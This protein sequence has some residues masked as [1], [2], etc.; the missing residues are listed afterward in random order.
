M[1]AKPHWPID[2]IVPG[3]LEHAG[4][5]LDCSSTFA[6]RSFDEV[7]GRFRSPC[8]WARYTLHKSELRDFPIS[9]N[10]CRILHPRIRRR[11]ECQK[12]LENVR[13][14]Q[15]GSSFRLGRMHLY[16]SRRRPRK[17]GFD[18]RTMRPSHRHSKPL[19]RTARWQ[20]F[21]CGW[22]ARGA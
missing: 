18:E 10:T 1:Q 14:L 20:T 19:A 17:V 21:Y 11:S 12:L 9:E 2:S 8:R 22:V 7:E 4:I 13:R 15:Q 5:D 6:A 16:S 3:K